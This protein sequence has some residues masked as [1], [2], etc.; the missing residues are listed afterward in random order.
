[1]KNTKAMATEYQM[2]RWTEVM[3]DRAAS[4]LSIRS[5]CRREGFHP[6]RYHYWQ[7]KLR[8]VAAAELLLPIEVKAS[9][10][11]PS[12]WTEIETTPS[13][14]SEN[15][16]VTIEIGKSRIVVTDSTDTALLTKICGVLLELC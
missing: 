14:K 5:Y 10:P 16:E 15:N 8:E 12:G 1:M 4:G 3:R 11:V 9:S 6:N 7:R 2:V 13:K